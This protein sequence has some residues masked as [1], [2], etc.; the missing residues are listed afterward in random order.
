MARGGQLLAFSRT[1]DLPLVT[2][3]DIIAY[4]GANEAAPSPY[5]R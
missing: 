2:V 5:L 3:A 1:H 4:R